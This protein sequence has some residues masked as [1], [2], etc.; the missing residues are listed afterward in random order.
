MKLLAQ[1][2]PERSLPR[3]PDPPP[4]GRRAPSSPSP[5]GGQAQEGRAHTRRP[6]QRPPATWVSRGG[7]E[8]SARPGRNSPCDAKSDGEAGR[9]ASTAQRGPGTRARQ[10][11]EAN[12]RPEQRNRARWYRLRTPNTKLLETADLPPSPGHPAMAPS[13]LDSHMPVRK[14]TGLRGPRPLSGDRLDLPP[15]ATSALLPIHRL[16]T[17][18][19][20]ADQVS[21][22]QNWPPGG[23]A[24]GRGQ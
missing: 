16:S 24:S 22:P 4:G 11:Q 5:S 10:S 23:E 13:A 2:D 19:V 8:M 15:H 3:R 12:R 7:R 9:S 1:E 21:T 18:R 17:W 14:V 20:S 6:P